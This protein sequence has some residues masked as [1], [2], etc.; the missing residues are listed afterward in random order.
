MNVRAMDVGVSKVTLADCLMMYEGGK[1]A[2]L[3][4][5]EVVNFEEDED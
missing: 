1:R 2:V 5:G 3:N 4:D